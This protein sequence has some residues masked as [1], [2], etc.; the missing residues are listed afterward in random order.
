MKVGAVIVG[1][2]FGRRMGQAKANISL[3]G[4][5]LFSYSLETFLTV[6]SIKQVVLVLQKQHFK[7][8][9][10][11]ISGRGVVL[12][13]GGKTRKQSVLN[14]LNKIKSN[15]RYVLIHD[16]ARP[17]VKKQTVLK[18]INGLKEYP[19]VIP[20]IKTKDTLKQIEGGVVKKTLERENIF[21][22]QTPQGFRKDLI[23]AAYKKY[24]RLQ[25]TDSAQ[26]FEKTG[27]PV[28]VV[29]GDLFNFKL[30][31]RED[32]DLAKAVEKYGKI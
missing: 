29:E 25:I 11:F 16:C 7:F 30:T 26:F 14:G 9:D 24:Q 18:V 19:A 32:I 31:Y 4:R 10:K 27:H 1:A 21:S 15:L 3:A 17:F 20:G 23:K 13:E 8:A 22:I 5:L 6:G 28:K 2:G 12:A